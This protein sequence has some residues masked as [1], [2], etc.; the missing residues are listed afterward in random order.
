QLVVRLAAE[1]MGRDGLI[2]KEAAA[3]VG[4]D[5]QHLATL[6]AN[7]K[8]KATTKDMMAAITA[9][10]A[11]NKSFGAQIRQMS[12]ALNAGAARI[13]QAPQG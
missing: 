5:P 13:A 10:E 11:Q 6:G 2:G 9:A 4:V 8:A 7:G 12:A 3:A 1:E